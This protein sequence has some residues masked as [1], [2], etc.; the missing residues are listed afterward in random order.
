MSANS[1]GSRAVNLL[2]KHRV[3]FLATIAGLGGL[4]AGELGLT[5]KSA[6]DLFPSAYAQ[7]LQRPSG[8]ADVVDKV[9]PTVVSVKVQMNTSG[10]TRRFDEDRPQRGTR[11]FGGQPFGGQRGTPFDDFFRRFGE[12]G[13]PFGQPDGDGFRHQQLRQFATAQGSGFFISAD[14]YAVTNNHVVDGAQR[15]EITTDDGKTYTA[16]VVGT[17]PRSDLAL[18]K[19]DGRS[20]FPFVRLADRNP[21]NALLL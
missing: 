10:N 2:S 3:A 16:R 1:L 17:D 5:P 8:F 15:V 21:R 11:P 20:D 18:I 13:Q 6:S 7:M 12:G 14:G 4:A 19:V 9:K